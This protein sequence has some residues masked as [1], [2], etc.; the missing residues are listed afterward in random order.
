[1]H[2]GSVRL[3][4]RM[5]R[6]FSAGGTYTYSKSIDNAASIGGGAQVVAQ[7]DTNLGRA[8]PQQL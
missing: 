4:K 2:A 8:R 5:A 3:R 1:M 7:D 6:G